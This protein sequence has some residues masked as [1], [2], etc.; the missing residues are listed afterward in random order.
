MFQTL[1]AI[2]KVFKDSTGN[3]RFAYPEKKNQYSEISNKIHHFATLNAGGSSKALFKAYNHLR[4][5][6][7]DYLPLF[8]HENAEQCFYT[9]MH[10]QSDDFWFDQEAYIA[11]HGESDVP[12]AHYQFLLERLNDPAKSLRF[13]DC[14]GVLNYDNDAELEVFRKLTMGSH[15]PINE[16]IPVYLLPTQNSSDLFARMINGYFND[17]L[18]PRQNYAL[19]QH[20]TQNYGYTLMG[21]GATTLLF[22]RNKNPDSTISHSILEDLSKLYSIPSDKMEK[23]GELIAVNKFLVLP[24]TESLMSL[25]IDPHA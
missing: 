5:E 22:I 2:V 24:Y 19:I 9:N 14:F 25:P 15:L 3:I 1:K 23:A 13:E 7:P 16:D 17:D 10:A 12:L 4:K 6:H 18:Q 8:I 20:F 11:Q 21:I